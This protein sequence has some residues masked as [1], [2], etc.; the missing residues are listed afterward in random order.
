[1][2]GTLAR[3]LGG[4]DYSQ[5]AINDALLILLSIYPEPRARFTARVDFFSSDGDLMAWARCWPYV[6]DCSLAKSSNRENGDTVDAQAQLNAG[7]WFWEAVV[8]P[9]VYDGFILLRGL[10]GFTRSRQ[11]S[12]AS[13][14]PTQKP[15]CGPLSA[16]PGAGMAQQQPTGIRNQSGPSHHASAVK[17]PS[18]T[19]ER[20]TS[21]QPAGK[22]I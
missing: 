9:C 4:L 10:Y 19:A 15:T 14:K 5:S 12:R 18:S 2:V 1:M 21:R 22:F 20:V 7:W 8:G 3:R 11:F 16:K 17:Y 6:D 13:R